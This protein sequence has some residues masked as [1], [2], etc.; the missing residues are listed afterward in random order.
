MVVHDAFGHA[1]PI[2]LVRASGSAWRGSFPFL[3]LDVLGSVLTRMRLWTG[4]PLRSDDPENCKNKGTYNTGSLLGWSWL[5]PMLLKPCWCH[6]VHGEPGNDGRVHNQPPFLV[7]NRRK[8]QSTAVPVGLS[9]V[10]SCAASMISPGTPLRTCPVWVLGR[11]S[12]PENGR[13]D[14]LGA[15]DGVLHLFSLD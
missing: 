2:P 8:L 15:A 12:V 4:T 6:T 9:V 5:A 13:M 1:E 7:Q 10:R 14:T 3:L 11:P